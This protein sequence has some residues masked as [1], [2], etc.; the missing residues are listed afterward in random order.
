MEANTKK[1][2]ILNAILSVINVSLEII[3]VLIALGVVIGHWE[4]YK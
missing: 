3:L 2:P 4:L 1:H